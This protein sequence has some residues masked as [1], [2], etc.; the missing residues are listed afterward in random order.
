MIDGVPKHIAEY[1]ERLGVIISPSITS[2]YLYDVFKK[3]SKGHWV[4]IAHIGLINRLYYRDYIRLER[5]GA[6]PA[7]EADKQRNL[8]LCLTSAN[9]GLEDF[10]TANILWR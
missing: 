10:Y 9:Y 2:G 8:Y 6:V 3:S 5:A 7:G 4:R 1:A